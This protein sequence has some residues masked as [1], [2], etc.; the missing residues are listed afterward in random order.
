MK[1]TK[2]SSFIFVLILFFLS[3]DLVGYK[4]LYSDIREKY[5][6]ESKILFYQI[7]SITDE[8]INTLLFEYTTHKNVTL[9]KHRIV[10]TYLQNHDLNISLKEIHERINADDPRKPYHI[11]I[12]DKNLTIRNTTYKPDLGFNLSFAKQI[13]ETHFKRRE[14][15]YSAPIQNKP[16]NQFFSFTDSYIEKN[17]DPKA[18]IMQIGYI[19]HDTSD[20]FSELQRFI[21]KHSRIKEIKSYGYDNNNF[22]YEIALTT[23]DS[24][25]KPT[26]KTLEKARQEAQTTLKKLGDHILFE[27]TYKIDGTPYRFL[28]ISNKSGISR[29]MSIIYT[30]WIDESDLHLMLLKLDILMGILTLFGMLAIV[31]IAKIRDKEQRLSEQDSFIQSVMHEIKT[32]LS[33]ITLNNE[34]RAMEYGSD[35]YTKEI[36]SAVKTLKNSYETMSFI[37]TKE[38]VDYPIEHLDLAHIVQERV[39]F[40]QSIARSNEKTIMTDIEGTCIVHISYIELI[41]FIDN[42][43]SNAIKYSE[44]GSSIMVTVRERT[45]SF[46]NYG[47]PIQDTTKVFERYV[48]ENRTV[49]GYGL[50]LNIIKSIAEKYGIYIRVD[51]NMQSGTT[52]YYTFAEELCDT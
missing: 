52:F 12:T 26:L 7:K 8:L 6:Q 36:D 19:Y 16:S 5:D 3:V 43:L 24:S 2:I 17:G 48:R 28:A 11:Y 42:N 20:I 9:E 51:S 21:Q 49:G 38:S 35:P 27:E 40:F 45:L 34:L 14:I 33:I 29:D 25:E 18:A 47:E 50:G 44:S 37:L 39:D 4:L 15:G 10:Q 41:R 1:H 22:F 13:F 46:H 30:I 31:I 32:P 23:T